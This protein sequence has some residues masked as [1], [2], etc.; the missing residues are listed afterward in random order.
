MPETLLLE[1]TG[2]VAL[3]TLNQPARR[4]P[5][6]ERMGEELAE[7]LGGVEARQDVRVLVL[8]GS[9]ESFC[10]GGDMALIEANTRRDV[11]ARRQVM[12][13]YYE[14][15]L[16]LLRLPIPTIAAVHGHAVGG[17]LA[18]ALACDLRYAAEDARPGSTSRGWGSTPAWPR[19]DPAARGRRGA[20]AGALLH[21]PGGVGREAEAMGLVNR[22]VPARRAHGHGARSWPSIAA[23]RRWSCAMLKRA[24]YQGLESAVDRRRGVRG[25]LPGHHLR[26]RGPPGRAR[27]R[28]G[29]PRPALR[30]PVTRPGGN[31]AASELYLRQMEL[32]PMQNFVYL[33]G[34]RW[35]ASASWSTRRGRSTP[36]WTRRGRRHADH[37]RARHPHPP[38]PRGRQPG[39]LGDARPDPR[40]RG[41]PGAG[42]GQGLRP[43]GRARVPQ[44]FGSDLVQVDS[45]DGPPG[46]ADHAHVRP[47][48]GAH[49]GLPVLPRRRPPR[50]PATPSSSGSCGRTDLPGGDPTEMHFSLTQRLGR[51]PRRHVLF[52]ATTT[53][54]RARPSAPR[55]AQNPFLRMGLGDFLRTMG[56]GRIVL[57]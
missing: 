11:E 47:H 55:S 4:N 32:G 26:E 42:P 34:D 51:A 44:G 40:G 54:A 8:A 3:L 48:A 1:V 56:G 33:V 57:P 35:R 43:P 31:A 16:T 21:G 41:A 46:G 29:A 14:R 49:A 53:A 24:V 7:T 6:S 15:Y 52:P 12:R 20:G 25:L 19:P 36:S 38:G 10:A 37:R 30:G 13:A 17:G 5:M 18:L 39:R 27:R 2:G 50:S 22:A 9:G 28:A 23:A 45:R